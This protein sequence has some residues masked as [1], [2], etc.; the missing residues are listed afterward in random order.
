VGL[1]NKAD[2]WLQVRPGTDG[3]LALGLIHLLIREGGY[4]EQFTREW[5]RNPAVQLQ[6]PPRIEPGT[7]RG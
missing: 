2:V 3:A 4:D 7:L 1:A 5:V 6:I